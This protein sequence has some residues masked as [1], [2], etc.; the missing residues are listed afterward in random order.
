MSDADTDNATDF[1]TI[2]ISEDDRRVM[3]ITLHRPAVH[4]AFNEKLIGELRQVLHR[5]RT[6]VSNGNEAAP[7]VVV[8]TGHGRSFCSG[9][10]F[11]WLRRQKDYSYEENIA[12]AYELAGLLDDLYTLPVP[13]IA[14]VN[15]AAIGG[16]AGLLACCDIPIAS[17]DARFDF[18]EVKFGIVPAVV[19][20]YVIRRIGERHAREYMLTGE[21]FDAARAQEIGLVQLAVEPELLD[22]A[23]QSRVDQLLTG[24]P[25]A[26]RACKELIADIVG[27]P[28]ED[29]ASFTADVIARLRVSDEGQE[30]ISAYLE[31]RPPRW[32]AD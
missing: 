15:G 6:E 31:R 23:V 26:V 32:M 12:D 13:T 18:S 30:G 2:L 24:G 5:I 4:N 1:Q 17:S 20:P 27:R 9:V 7:R 10:D 11:E 22:D 21:R 16:G 19:G 14:R 28:L 25:E 29:I 8:L 3:T